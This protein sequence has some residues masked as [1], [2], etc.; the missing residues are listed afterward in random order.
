MNLFLNPAAQIVWYHSVIDMHKRPKPECCVHS[1]ETKIQ[2]A[3]D[4]GSIREIIMKNNVIF[5]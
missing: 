4:M 1:A 3:N 2:G 5:A